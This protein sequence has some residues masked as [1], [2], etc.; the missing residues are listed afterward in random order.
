[1]SGSRKLKKPDRRA[2]SRGDSLLHRLSIRRDRPHSSGSNQSRMSLSSNAVGS[3]LITKDEGSGTNARGKSMDVD[4]SLNFGLLNDKL[5]TPTTQL[6][7][8]SALGTEAIQTIIQV[9]G[10]F[11]VE[12]DDVKQNYGKEREREA[13]ED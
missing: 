4:Q 5:Q 2:E 12:V 6:F 1:M 13:K 10:E 11:R 3:N 8:A 9:L 7:Q